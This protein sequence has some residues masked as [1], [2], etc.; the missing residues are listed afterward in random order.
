M[1]AV[2]SLRKSLIAMTVV[3]SPS[4]S[5]V[6]MIAGIAVGCVRGEPDCWDCCGVCERRA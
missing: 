3:A 4:K 5:L 6:A 2:A 1:S